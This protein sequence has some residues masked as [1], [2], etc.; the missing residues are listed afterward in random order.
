MQGTGHANGLH[1]RAAGRGQRRE[2]VGG[3][4]QTKPA[5]GPTV[6]P[7]VVT[8]KLRTRSSASRYSSLELAPTGKDQQ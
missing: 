4:S 6:N 7:T 2:S 5:S 8:S 1:E 3:K